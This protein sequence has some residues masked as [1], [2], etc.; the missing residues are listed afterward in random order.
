[1]EPSN[2]PAIQTSV[3]MHQYSRQLF[4]ISLFLGGGLSLFRPTFIQ[5]ALSLLSAPILLPQNIQFR[6]I[7]SS[8]NGLG[9]KSLC[10]KIYVFI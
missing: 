6:N 1:M 4:L 2:K 3:S 8:L 5:I 7:Y 10:S 9:T